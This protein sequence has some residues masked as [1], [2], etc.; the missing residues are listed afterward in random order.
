MP[1]AT[2]NSYECPE[3]L[4]REF[5]ERGSAKGLDVSCVEKLK[6]QPFITALPPLA[7]PK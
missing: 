5:I 6:R 7:I 4:A 2:H 1:N 3:Q